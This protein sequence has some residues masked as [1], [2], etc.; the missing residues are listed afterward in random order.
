[1]R[2][3]CMKPVLLCFSSATYVDS[4]RFALSS[5][6]L[7]TP[8]VKSRKFHLAWSPF[9]FDDD[10]FTQVGWRMAPFGEGPLV[11][12]GCEE[13]SGPRVVEKNDVEV[14]E[15]EEVRRQVSAFDWWKLVLLF[16]G[17]L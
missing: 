7:P 13:T 6:A 12:R 2:D 16:S 8:S 10:A 15:E 9:E 14:E 4:M 11:L 1:M 5:A 3:S 17:R